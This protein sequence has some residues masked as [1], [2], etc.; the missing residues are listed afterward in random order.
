TDATACLDALIAQALHWQ[1]SDIHFEPFEH[2]L[3]V[4]CRV[5]GRLRA[6]ASP[7]PA[8]RERLLS[9]L[10]VLARL[11]IADKR[12]AQDGQLNW[13]QQGQTVHLRVS[14]LPTL[15]GEKIVLR[16]LD[17]RQ[18]PLSLPALGYTPRDLAQLTQALARPHGMVLLTG[19]TGSGKT[20][21]LYSCLAHLQHEAVNIATVEDPSEIPLDGI[22]QVSV[23]ERAGL[24]F[25]QAL[26][27][28]LRQDPDILMVGEMRD[29]ETAGIA[30]QAA[31]TGHLVLST[32]HSNDAPSALWRLVQLGLERTQVA[33]TV[34]LIVAQRLVRRLCTHCRIPPDTE[35]GTWTALGC[36]LC[37][38]GYRGRVGL[39]QVMPISATMQGL[40]SAGADVQT[41]S[42]QAQEEGVRSVFEDGCD[43]AR[44]GLTTL[45]EVQ[46]AAHA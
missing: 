6:M 44:Q 11:D 33:H 36:H 9:R 4:R 43:K 39:F 45:T 37:H 34:H 35:A 7:S 28:L 19:P 30:L 18:L 12:I 38:E 20:A 26:R 40:I 17:T 22:N 42:R 21:T 32:L 24:G 3:R 2:G 16:V 15:Q 46:G 14:T 10:K 29:R 27:A 5:D 8:L 23:N 25:A 41:L 31:Q 13:S 1:A